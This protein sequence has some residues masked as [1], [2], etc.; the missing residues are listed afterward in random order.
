[1]SALPSRY[2]KNLRQSD[3]PG[4]ESLLQ[5][6]QTYRAIVRRQQPTLFLESFRLLARV[7]NCFVVNYCVASSVVRRILL[8]RV[9]S[10]RVRSTPPPSRGIATPATALTGS[11]QSAP[12][13][14]IVVGNA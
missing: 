2:A 7:F 13:I 8:W 11:L 1:M 4:V 9:M 10:C 6:G 5:F 3:F 12:T 14:S